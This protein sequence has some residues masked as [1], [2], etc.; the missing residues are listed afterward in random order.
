VKEVRNFFRRIHYRIGDQLFSPDDVEHGILRGNKAS[1]YSLRSTYFSGSDGRLE[2]VILPPDPR[3]HFAIVCASSSCPPIGVYTGEG[4]DEELKIAAQAS[5]NGGMVKVR[6]SQE[7]VYLSK[8][9]YWY[10]ADFGD[11]EEDIVKFII[12][13]LYDDQERRYLS[14]NIGGVRV[15]YQDYDWRLNRY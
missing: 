9:F 13:Y 12:P 11:G 15:T 6:K 4:I 10:G 7:T 5:L 2:H 3:I 14:E 1:P 8:I